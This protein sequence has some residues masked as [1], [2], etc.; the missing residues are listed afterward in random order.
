LIDVAASP[1]PTL[2]RS[3]AIES[4]Q[5][6][7]RQARQLADNLVRKAR[8]YLE[9]S[10]AMFFPPDISHLGYARTRRMQPSAD[11]ETRERAAA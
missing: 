8:L 4:A 7:D 10:W 11:Q 2:R 6:A 5:F 9:W 3:A 1:R